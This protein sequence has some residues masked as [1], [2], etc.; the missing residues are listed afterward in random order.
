MNNKIDL[1]MYFNLFNIK[2]KTV[3][4]A[5]ISDAFCFIDD[6]ITF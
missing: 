6:V 3:V 4:V 2:S 1:S 5:A